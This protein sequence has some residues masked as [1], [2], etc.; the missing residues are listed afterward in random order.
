MCPLN[1]ITSLGIV[2]L[3]T[4]FFLPGKWPGRCRRDTWK[5]V[6]WPMPG[7]GQGSRRDEAR[8]LREARAA[9]HIRHPNVVSVFDFGIEEDLAFLVMELV[10]GETLAA[11][12]GREGPLGIARTLELLLRDGPGGCPGASGRGP[13]RRGGVCLRR[14][15]VGGSPAGAAARDRAGGRAGAL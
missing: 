2:S 12:L 9:A 8:F 3:S 4:Y 6:A 13:G 14:C 15:R 7:G 10:E 11:L 5:R 1:S